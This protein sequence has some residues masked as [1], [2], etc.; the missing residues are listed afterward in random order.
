MTR[1]IMTSYEEVFEHNRQ[2]AAERKETDP[3]YFTRLSREQ[4]PGYLYIGCSDSRVP[5]SEIMGVEPGEV[6]V[7]RNIAN[8]VNNT[9]LNV[10][11]VIN[12]AVRHLDVEHIVVCGHYHCGG[13]SAALQSQDLGLLNPWLRNVRDVY[14]L[15]SKELSAITDP[16]VRFD[17]LVELNVIE[18]CI[19]VA[20]TAAVQQ[21]YL[22][23]GHPIVHGW[24]FDLREG[25]LKDLQVDFPQILRDIQQIYDLTGGA[26]AGGTPGG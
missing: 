17:R 8:L 18:Q 25:I 7:H 20:K 23:R 15:H 5:A 12:Y 3:D 11:S 13:V 26:P 1:V 22:Q 16:T 24:V 2:W 21:A 4:N 9:D 19:N 10:M 14:R 6:F